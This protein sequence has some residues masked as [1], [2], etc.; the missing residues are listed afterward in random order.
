MG[1]MDVRKGANGK[2]RGGGKGAIMGEVGVNGQ[3]GR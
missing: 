3:R 1:I 2:G